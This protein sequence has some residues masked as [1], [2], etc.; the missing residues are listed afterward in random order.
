ML[1]YNAP[2]ESSQDFQNR[3][4]VDKMVR[5][6]FSLNSESYDYFKNQIFTPEVD[7]G[8]AEIIGDSTSLRFEKSLDN[9]ERFEGHD[10][11]WQIFRSKFYSFVDRYRVTYKIFRSGKVEIKKNKLKLRKALLK[12]YLGHD[13]LAIINRDLFDA[14][15]WNLIITK[16]E[17]NE[18]IITKQIDSV[19][20]RV[21][22]NSITKK[23]NI[24]AVISANFADWFLCSTGESWSSCLSLTTDYEYAYWT[25]LPGL[26]GDKN[27]VMVYITNGKKKN[28]HGIEV[29]S[30]I[31]RC[32]GILGEDGK[33]NILTWYPNTMIPTKELNNIFGKDIFANE[34]ETEDNDWVSKHPIRPLWNSE[35]KSR[36]IYQD[37]STFTN[38]GYI[39]NSDSGHCYFRYNELGETRYGDMYDIPET[40]ENLMEMGHTIDNYE[41]DNYVCCDCGERI[42]DD[43]VYNAPNGD[44]MCSYCFNE[45]YFYCVSCNRTEHFDDGVTNESTGEIYCH[46]CAD[47]HLVMSQHD[48]YYYEREDCYEIVDSHGYI[49]GHILKREVREGYADY[50]VLND[51]RVCNPEDSIELNNGS[52]KLKVAALRDGDAVECK[53]TDEVILKE[54]ATYLEDEGAWIDTEY[55]KKY[56]DS[57]Q[58]KL[59]LGIAS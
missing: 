6:H 49:T 17:G 42:N 47:N 34:K 41:Y 22:D 50:I 2:E 33:I 51:D 52:V 43:E 15:H 46:Y 30:M 56:Q 12:F 3:K 8:I 28:F 11:G 53:Y 29:D 21:N 26:I 16:I 35:G 31:T 44:V 40:F 25:G 38:K 9:L 5:E 23:N 58:F 45:S 39:K 48:D 36:F 54:D 18:E 32:W 10:E 14:P 4:I 20:S 37:Y 24:K 13:N 19:L 7:E 57:L 55:L 27:R 59:K 1:R